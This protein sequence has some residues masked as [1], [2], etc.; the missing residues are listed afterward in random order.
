MLPYF[1]IRFAIA[2]SCLI[3]SAL[4]L[5]VI[6]SESSMSQTSVLEADDREV[7]PAKVGS[8]YQLFFS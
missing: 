4:Q 6:F 2:D 5:G 3:L 1:Q 8:G 7:A